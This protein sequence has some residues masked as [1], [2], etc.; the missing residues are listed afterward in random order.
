MVALLVALF[1]AFIALSIAAKVVWDHVRYE[2]LTFFPA[3]G[4]SSL[5]GLEP[6]NITLDYGGITLSGWYM[7]S[8]NGAPLAILA[9]GS[10]GRRDQL[11]EEVRLLHAQGI[12][13]LAFDFP[14]HGLSEGKVDCEDQPSVVRAW[15]THAQ[16]L[17]PMSPVTAL[18]FSMGGYA[19]A[20]AAARDPRIAAVVLMGTFADALE[21]T[22]FEHQSA[23]WLSQTAAIWTDRFYGLELSRLRP[24]E[25]VTHIKQPL[26]IIHG[27]K[28]EVV[29]VDQARALYAAANEP[30]QLWLIEEA[31]HGGYLR[32]A[33]SSANLLIEFIRRTALP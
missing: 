32:A 22:K 31:H 26:L 10:I 30:K 27:K 17:Q 13:V 23:G 18:G 19:V 28:D 25:S 16:K 24:L 5:E 12:G 21:Q 6:E 3:R 2:R 1:V 4:A 33:G 29:S 20:S 14:G 11:V 15:V 8:R 7:P 9:H